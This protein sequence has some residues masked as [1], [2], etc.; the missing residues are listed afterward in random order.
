MN[1][2]H[3]LNIVDFLPIL[4]LLGRVAR[5]QVLKKNNYFKVGRY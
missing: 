2:L 1:T 4:I 5:L 3:I